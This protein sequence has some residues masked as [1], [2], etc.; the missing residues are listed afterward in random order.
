MDRQWSDFEKYVF[1]ELNEISTRI[2]RLEGRA[3]AW[4]AIAGLIA[5]AAGEVFIKVVF[6]N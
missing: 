4:G 6:K 1:K 3:M 2:H 5:T